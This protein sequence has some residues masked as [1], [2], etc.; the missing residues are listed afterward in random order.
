MNSNQIII[1]IITLVVLNWLWDQ[2]IK[3]KKLALVD[4]EKPDTKAIEKRKKQLFSSRIIL[5]PILAFPLIMGLLFTNKWFETFNMARESLNWKAVNG[6]V[7]DKKVHTIIPGGSKNTSTKSYEYLPLIEYEYYINDKAFKSK[8]INYHQNLAYTETDDVQLYL[9]GFPNTGD[10][11]TVYTTTVKTPITSKIPD[12]VITPE[13]AYEAHQ[14]S[15]LIPGIE[16]MNYLSLILTNIFTLIGL[17]GFK[18]LY[19]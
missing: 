9:D 7:I 12:S 19:L 18:K 16:G 6:V 14:L 5:T 3:R 15:V 4:L 8:R 2:R 10:K 1:A 13:E 17:V 11:I